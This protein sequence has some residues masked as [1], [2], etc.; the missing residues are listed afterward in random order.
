[1]R[2]KI[3]SITQPAHERVAQNTR[4]TNI[5]FQSQKLSSEHFQQA[6]N[7]AR[8]NTTLSAET[9][10]I[11]K[12][13]ARASS[14]PEKVLRSDHDIRQWKNW[15][16]AAKSALLRRSPSPQELHER[17]LRLQQQRKQSALSIARQL[18][19]TQFNTT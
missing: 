17:P 12:V 6:L 4:K 16:G 5:L 11:G 15:Q 7:S 8:R 19:G 10:T 13:R 3:S 1:M 9:A 14:L 2:K 18:L